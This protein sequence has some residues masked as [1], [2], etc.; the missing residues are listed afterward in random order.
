VAANN[1]VINQKAEEAYTKLR[2][3]YDKASDKAAFIAAISGRV[4]TGSPNSLALKRLE[5]EHQSG[6]QPA[7][8]TKPPAGT[9]TTLFKSKDPIH[10]TSQSGKD[11]N[12]FIESGPDSKGYYHISIPNARGG[13]ASAV[14]HSSLL[15]A[16]HTGPPKAGGDQPVTVNVPRE[17]TPFQEYHE[18]LRGEA[19][20]AVKIDLPSGAD[21]EYLTG[22]GPTAKVVKGKITGVGV[23]EVNKTPYYTVQFG[24][25]AKG[26]P[27]TRKVYQ[28][29][30]YKAQLF[31]EGKYTPPPRETELPPSAPK[32]E[33]VSTF[34]AAPAEP[35]KQTPATTVTTAATPTEAAAAVKSEAAKKKPTHKAIFGHVGGARPG[36]AVPKPG[37]PR[38]RQGL[39]DRLLGER[40]A[41]N[42]GMTQAELEATAPRKPKPPTSE[43]MSWNDAVRAANIARKSGISG[44]KEFLK[45]YEEGVDTNTYNTNVYQLESAWRVLGRAP[46]GASRIRFKDALDRAAIREEA[47]ARRAARGEAAP[48]DPTKSKKVV[49]APTEAVDFGTG[50][51]KPTKARKQAP[52]DKIMKDARANVTRGHYL[53]YQKYRNMGLPHKTSMELALQDARDA[54]AAERYDTVS[55]KGFRRMFGKPGAAQAYVKPGEGKR[56]MYEETGF[57]E[58]DV[59]GSTRAAL[60]QAGMDVEQP[61]LRG[62]KIVGTTAGKSQSQ[63]FAENV[64]EAEGMVE[65]RRGGAR[66]YYI[67]KPQRE[68]TAEEQKHEAF[69][70][71]M[72][73]DVVE[74]GSDAGKGVPHY[75]TPKLEGAARKAAMS[76]EPAA[77]AE[78]RI[79]SRPLDKTLRR[80]RTPRQLGLTNIPGGKAEVQVQQEPPIEQRPLKKFPP[81][82]V[83]KIPV[84]GGRHRIQPRP[85]PKGT[86]QRIRTY[87]PRPP[88]P[89]REKMETLK[90]TT[91][92]GERVYDEAPGGVKKPRTVFGVLPLERSR[93]LPKAP[94]DRPFIGAKN[95]PPA[96]EPAR[97]HE[98]SSAVHPIGGAGYRAAKTSAG[99][100]VRTRLS[101]T[102]ETVVRQGGAKPFTVR[103]PAGISV[104]EAKRVNEGLIAQDVDRLLQNRGPK[105]VSRYRR[106]GTQMQETGD[107]AGPGGLQQVRE[108]PH[109]KDLTVAEMSL[110]RQH[111]QELADQQPSKLAA[112]ARDR[113]ESISRRVAALQAL[114][115]TQSTKLERK[116]FFKAVEAKKSKRADELQ[117]AETRIRAYFAES[118]KE[119][120]TPQQ[121]QAVGKKYHIEPEELAALVNKSRKALPAPPTRPPLSARLLSDDTGAIGWGAG[122]LIAA[123]RAKRTATIRVPDDPQLEANRAA[124]RDKDPHSILNVFDRVMRKAV[125]RFT[126]LDRAEKISGRTWRE[127][128]GPG[129]IIRSIYGGA[130]G[131][132]V[133]AAA[134]MHKVEVK[135]LRQ[136]PRHDHKEASKALDYALAYN[137]IIHGERMIAD[138]L[139][140]AEDALQR[141]RQIGIKKNIVAAQNLVKAERGRLRSFTYRGTGLAGSKITPAEASVRLNQL[142]GSLPQTHK[143]YVNAMLT[144]T[145]KQFKAL[146]DY[147]VYRGVVSPGTAA[148]WKARGSYLGALYRKTDAGFETGRSIIESMRASKRISAS[149]AEVLRQLMG[150]GDAPI[151]TGRDSV[152]RTLARD[153]RN[154]ERAD[155]INVLVRELG[156]DPMLVRRAHTLTEPVPHGYAEV[157]SWNN[158]Q[159]ERWFLHQDL[160]A[161]VVAPTLLELQLAGLTTSKLHKAN[162]AVALMG[163]SWSPAW[164]LWRN[165][166]RDP[167][168]MRLGT[169]TPSGQRVF[170]PN[171]VDYFKSFTVEW[172]QNFWKVAANHPDYLDMLKHRGGN[173]NLAAAL[174]P[175]HVLGNIIRRSP[176][177]GAIEPA[178]LKRTIA[179]I[180]TRLGHWMENTPKLMGYMRLR[181][182]GV[183]A[184]TAGAIARKWSG[185]PDFPTFGGETKAFQNTFGI[186]LSATV[187]EKARWART[188]REFAEGSLAAGRRLSGRAR[189]ASI[190]RVGWIIAGTTATALA[191]AKWN[192]QFT[193]KDGNPA[194]NSI[195]PRILRD[196][197]VFLTG[198]ATTK[199]NGDEEFIYV[200]FPKETP[201]Q[202]AAPLVFELLKFGPKGDTAGMQ[203]VAEE[204]F[205]AMFPGRADADFRSVGKAIKS[206]ARGA[207]SVVT[208]II[209]G[210]INATM[211]T[212]L[213]SGR[214]IHPKSLEGLS[215]DYQ[216]TA[217]THE[218]AI[219][220]AQAL[221]EAGLEVSPKQVEYLAKTIGMAPGSIGLDLQ[222]LIEERAGLKVL[223]TSK[224]PYQKARKNPLYGILVS[225]ATGPGEVSGQELLD[226]NRFYEKLAEANTFLQDR[227]KF[228]KL[229]ISDPEAKPSGFLESKAGKF[230]EESGLAGMMGSLSQSKAELNA[231]SQDLTRE[232]KNPKTTPERRKE[233]EATL[234]EFHQ[235][236]KKLLEIFKTEVLQEKPQVPRPPIVG[237]GSKFFDL[238]N[239]QK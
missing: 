165:L 91:P 205:N 203:K 26:Q 232:Y 75:P 60:V 70:D 151:I 234:Q 183:D 62:K 177:T 112:I 86:Q 22:S 137:Q 213:E 181:A 238:R 119:Y 15:V 149:D 89:A 207:W 141:A 74:G 55:I 10:Y 38:H 185:S 138:R 73:K 229:Q 227:A 178:P 143:D 194:V 160:A 215:S 155:A 193:D 16:G 139:K 167:K 132:F 236:E 100:N 217:Y 221:T 127:G 97:P 125:D 210:P 77:R 25:D 134:E 17:K 14:R 120:L 220:W 150:V 169:M 148:R 39:F 154:A 59:E 80:V 82:D 161:P 182:Q 192:S 13:S 209:R 8:G 180:P 166:I 235:V 152:Y 153:Y 223:P 46:K 23:S 95:P 175:E 162:S 173:S 65:Y 218:S 101:P 233:I 117:Q 212:E 110:A 158:G 85:I 36:A 67:P 145:D 37:E 35:Q 140:A 61:G 71:K 109:V 186:Y 172:A 224:D 230:W 99:K 131:R 21:V 189:A 123:H 12:G 29:Q 32:I 92:S 48:F 5:M 52:P 219:R 24:V 68:L 184:D 44:K 130:S 128:E 237:L 50:E 79:P 133:A 111:Y 228:Q 3:R 216:F 6:F 51:A 98:V 104:R 78:A 108:V 114:Q 122:N 9:T 4:K 176:S 58:G 27:K 19:S 197:W 226:N 135:H 118:G 225:A 88:A 126:P 146:L 222:D 105:G 47:E 34:A 196:N 84:G 156:H 31:K 45:L 41:V 11:V 72:W 56:V 116:L 204:W 129:D 157:H 49:A 187:A 81:P 164:Q 64:G 200:K 208:P 69:L 2:E 170:K 214:A 188:M 195:D 201:Q 136:I 102:S 121:M 83:E 171:P 66:R 33:G 20:Q 96:T 191:N 174:A 239:R 144:E 211:Q 115:D 147:S 198:A 90:P 93:E 94:K 53:D 163:T 103:K 106:A 54:W 199:P 28:D 76:G 57:D 7:V 159:P 107:L 43:V 42:I 168:A 124:V 18:K 1:A 179:T 206:V 202:L 30:V 231:L 142:M 63:T 190:R 87:L 40:G 113:N